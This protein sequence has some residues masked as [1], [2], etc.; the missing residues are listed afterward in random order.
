MNAS[1]NVTVVICTKNRY[2][3]VSILLD[4]YKEIGFRGQIFLADGSDHL[5]EVTTH[6]HK[7]RIRRIDCRGMNIEQSF[8]KAVREVQTDYVAYCG[9]DDFLLPS[10]L[11][12]C[13]TFLNENSDFSAC[14]A[15]AGYLNLGRKGVAYDQVLPY[16]TREYIDDCLSE[17]LQDMICGFYAAPW[18][19]IGTDRVKKNLMASSR[20]KNAQAREVYLVFGALCQGMIKKLSNCVYVVRGVHGR[21]F[22][23]P[24]NVNTI[25][26]EVN[27]AVRK[28][29]EG[30]VV[31]DFLVEDIVEFHCLSSSNQK[32]RISVDRKTAKRFKFFDNE[33]RNVGV[34]FSTYFAMLKIKVLLM[35]HHED[36]VLRKYHNRFLEKKVF[37]EAI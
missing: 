37:K 33:L 9:D 15:Q 22:Q 10:G 6:F 35:W 8:L 13:A 4:F 17:R 30:R 20:F 5:M 14:T 16:S 18:F 11:E 21:N 2:D 27:D 34:R 26:D 32:K 24:A 29:V 19:L 36:A 28:N 31:R 23:Y 7:E 25:D 1:G 3:S 12:K